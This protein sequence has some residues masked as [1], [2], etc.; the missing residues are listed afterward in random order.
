[1]TQRSHWLAAVAAASCLAV[2]G[3]AA[4]ADLLYTLESTVTLPSTDTGWDYVKMEPKTNRL[5]MARDKDG[6]TLFDVDAGKAVTTIENSVGANGPL[7]LPQYNRGYVA[8][9]DGSFLSFDL[10]TLKPIDRIKLDPNGGINSAILDPFTKQVHAIVGTRPK[11]SIWYTLDAATAKLLKKTTFPFRKMD[12]PATD[13]KGRIFAPARKD[14]LILILDSETLAEKARWTAPC[15]VSKVRFQASTNRILAACL[16]NEALFFAVNAGTGAI[17]A[18][19]PIGK[20]LDGFYIDEQRKRIV[21]SNYEGTLTVIRQ[22]SADSYTLL[23]TI[24]TSPGARMMAM[25]DRNGKLYVVNATYTETPAA[26]GETSETYHPNS[27]V[28]MTFKPD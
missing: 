7:L 9:T 2:T 4:S 16:A 12:D 17:V 20:V 18:Q 25:D 15:N 28:V 6:L 8:M 14:N 5:F 10:K 19:L 13:G 24:N 22:D 3:T 1:M 26:N 23:G 27:F 21:T 11:E